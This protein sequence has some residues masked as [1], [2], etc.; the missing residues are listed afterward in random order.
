PL[1]AARSN[2]FGRALPPS[3]DLSSVDVLR[4]P[5]GTLLGADTQGGAV[6]FEPNQPSLAV[7]SAQAHAELAATE[8]GEPSYE[9][10]A[11]AGGP[12][13]DGVLGFR[14]SAW[15]RSDGGYVDRVDPFNDAIV[16]A[17]A[18][19]DTTQ[20]VRGVLTYAPSRSWK[21]SPSINYVSSSAH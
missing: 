19:R 8:R 20:S 3:F 6:R 12:L 5:Q 15:R 14:F 4:G 2:T 1:P 18:N 9:A 7:Y 16:D 10:G 13:V 21:I 17:N 11:A